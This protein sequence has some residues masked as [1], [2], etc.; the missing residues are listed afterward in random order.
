MLLLGRWSEGGLGLWGKPAFAF[1]LRHGL[2]VLSFGFFLMMFVL[3]LRSVFIGL[4][5][6]SCH[7]LGL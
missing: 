6:R 3:V 7:S 1:C 2:L 4:R 5:G